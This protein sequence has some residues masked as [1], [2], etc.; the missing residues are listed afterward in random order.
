MIIFFTYFV[1]G[2]GIIL[3]EFRLH[4]SP[5]IFETM[6]REAKK[7]KSRSTSTSISVLDSL[8]VEVSESRPFSSNFV[9]LALVVF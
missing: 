2:I 1:G 4:H 7:R 9:Q 6:P 3:F 5:D 8:A